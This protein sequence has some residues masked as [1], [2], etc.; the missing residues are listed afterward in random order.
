MAIINARISEELNNSLS[1]LAKSLDRSKSYVIAKAIQNYVIE[2]LDDL[3]DAEIALS[4]MNNQ[5]RELYTSE[6][7]QQI[8]EAD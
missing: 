1:V 7:V 2:Q 4:R 6:E 3:E 8:L 5:D